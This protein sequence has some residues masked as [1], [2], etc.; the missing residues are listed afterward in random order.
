MIPRKLSLRLTK[1]LKG[2]KYLLALLKKF[3]SVL[4]DTIFLQDA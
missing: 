3:I 1:K 2:E 4:I